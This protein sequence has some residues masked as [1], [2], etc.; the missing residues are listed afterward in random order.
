MGIYKGV[1]VK[2]NSFYAILLGSKLSFPFAVDDDFLWTMISV[3]DD[4]CSFGG[5]ATN[6]LLSA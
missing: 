5:C 2:V 6:S 3:D 1:E 4:F